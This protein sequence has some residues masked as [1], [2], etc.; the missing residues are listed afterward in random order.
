MTRTDDK[1]NAVHLFCMVVFF[2]S[3]SLI[4]T[5]YYRRKD[6]ESLE[7]A[8]FIWEPLPSG[9]RRRKRG[10]CTRYQPYQTSGA[11]N[12]T[13]GACLLLNILRGSQNLQ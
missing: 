2:V 10:K 3:C 12:Q 5:F 9:P 11:S 13:K 7:V 1:V 8:E 4:E 6:Q